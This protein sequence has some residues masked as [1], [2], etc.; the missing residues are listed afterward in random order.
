MEKRV[1]LFVSYTSHWKC[2]FNS[3]F[4][5]AADLRTNK[6]THYSLLTTNNNNWR[7]VVQYREQQDSVH[8][9]I[10]PLMFFLCKSADYRS[11]GGKEIVKITVYY[12]MR[13]Y[14]VLLNYFIL[15]FLIDLDH[16]GSSGWITLRYFE[17]RQVFYYLV[18]SHTHHWLQLTA[19]SSLFL[20]PVPQSLFK[21]ENAWITS[22]TLYFIRHWK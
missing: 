19:P 16:L 21:L 3:N 1:S 17:H 22:M 4:I 13:M 7:V 10:A 8:V 11:R 20:A 9:I 18:I 15:T 12:T 2:N 6:T 14:S 5:K